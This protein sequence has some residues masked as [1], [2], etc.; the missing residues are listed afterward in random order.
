VNQSGNIVDSRAAAPLYVNAPSF[1]LGS[2]NFYPLP[3]K[4]RGAALDLSA[5][6]TQ[7]QYMLDFNG[8][9]K[10]ASGGVVFRGAYAGEGTNPGWQ[11]QGVPLRKLLGAQNG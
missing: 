6:S 9:R 4:A 7:T 2:M 10:D 8:N 1:A 3:G 11:P 5:F